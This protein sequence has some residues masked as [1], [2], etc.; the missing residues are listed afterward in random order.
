M[1]AGKKFRTALESNSPLVIPGTINAYSAILAEQAGHKAI[2]L[3]GGGVAAGRG[4]GGAD[5]RGGGGH[6]GV[7]IGVGVAGGEVVVE[8]VAFG[9]ALCH[10]FHQAL[11]AALH[12]R[13]RSRRGGLVGEAGVRPRIDHGDGLV[14]AIE[15]GVEQGIGDFHRVGRGEQGDA[16]HRVSGSAGGRRRHRRLQHA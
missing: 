3:S 14:H 12:P 7:A 11:A 15:R 6:R 9:V 8:D 4:A 10:A 5:G 1:T 2:Y 13:A 16:A